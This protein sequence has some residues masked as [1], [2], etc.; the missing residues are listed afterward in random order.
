MV[1]L[2]AIT[3]AVI[4]FS[5]SAYAY[6]YFHKE[7][8]AFETSNNFAILTVSDDYGFA[9][10]C[11]TDELQA[12]F[13]TPDQS[14]KEKDTLVIANSMLPK[15]LIRI[16]NKQPLTLAGTLHKG[17]NGL[18][19]QAD[20]DRSFVDDVSQARRRIAVAMDLLGDIYHETDFSASGSTRVVNKLKKT[21]PLFFSSS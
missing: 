20:I 12:R 2:A 8:S 19:M 10:R 17:N 4:L 11:T 3:I 21:C 18:V 5:N 6:W 1:R 9:I 14:F 7:D 15:L 13:F 16:D